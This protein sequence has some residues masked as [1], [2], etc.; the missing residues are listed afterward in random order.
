MNKNLSRDDYQVFFLKSLFWLVLTGIGFLLALLG[1]F[2]AEAV[3]VIAIILG[4]GIFYSN[5]KNEIS[6]PLSW[7]MLII[8][9]LIIITAVVF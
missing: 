1:F 2:Y 8:C 5:L 9:S 6:F 4:L 3:W 7:E